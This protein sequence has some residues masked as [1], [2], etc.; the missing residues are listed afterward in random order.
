MNNT[1]KFKV[2]DHTDLK[3]LFPEGITIKDLI[4]YF[5]SNFDR[6]NI[7]NKY[8]LIF[9]QYTGREDSFGKEIYHYDLVEA[10]KPNSYLNGT[11]LVIWD[12]KKSRWRY[13]MSDVYKYRYTVGT[14]HGNT[15]SKV[16]GNYYENPELH[17]NIKEEV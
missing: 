16:I 13:E 7:L 5:T 6:L 9:L 8:N 12:S 4:A 14:G 15:K 2:W 10:Y 3:M 1:L 11:Y 17:K